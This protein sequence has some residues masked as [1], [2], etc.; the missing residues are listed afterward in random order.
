L[1]IVA[2]ADWIKD[3]EA[4]ATR[5]VE[6]MLDAMRQWQNDS[7]SW[8]TPAESIF[9]NGGLSRAQLQQVWAEFRDGGY[10]SVNGGINF[11]AT[12]KLMDLYFQL[13]RESPNSS[14]S[15]PSDVYD[16]GPLQTALDKM[17]VVKGTPNLPD[18]PDWYQGKGLAAK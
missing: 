4:A 15:K 13:R 14:L 6:V 7:K 10:F 8:V 2:R 12:Q 5:Y 16:T 3:H 11:A 18:I 17:G 9:K 1:V